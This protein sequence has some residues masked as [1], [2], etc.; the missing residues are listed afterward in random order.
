MFIFD[1][2][3]RTVEQPSDIKEDGEIGVRDACIIYIWCPIRKRIF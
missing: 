2:I 3:V 1:W